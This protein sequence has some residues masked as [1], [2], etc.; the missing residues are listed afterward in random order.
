MRECGVGYCGCRASGINNKLVSEFY[1]RAVEHWPRQFH[2]R[3][4]ERVCV[5]FFVR[6]NQS[7]CAIVVKAT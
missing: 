3:F 6:Y 1:S 2:I 7:N 4:N 5:Y